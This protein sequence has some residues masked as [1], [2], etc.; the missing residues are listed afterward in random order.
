LEIDGPGEGQAA[1]MA[2]KDRLDFRQ[3]GPG[4][5]VIRLAG[6][7]AEDGGEF[8]HGRRLRDAKWEMENGNSAD[9]SVG[10]MGFGLEP[11]SQNNAK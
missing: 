7:G 6:T 11:G 9:S 2:G 4:G 10:C 5:G 3:D 8:F 1:G